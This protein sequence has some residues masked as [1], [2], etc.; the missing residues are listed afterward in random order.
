MTGR[1]QGFE[2][3]MTKIAISAGLALSALQGRVAQGARVA[4]GI[5]SSMGHAAASGARATPAMGALVRNAGQDVRATMS[6][7]KALSNPVTQGMQNRVAD[8]IR[9]EAG[10]AV[11]R[12]K[13]PLSSAYEGYMNTQGAHT[14][15]PQH[16]GHVL[17]VDPAGIKL[18]EGPTALMPRGNAS[19][20]KDVL[21]NAA[22]EID[23]TGRTHLGG[24]TQVGQ[25]GGRNLSVPSAPVVPLDQPGIGAMPTAG[26]ADR[27]NPFAGRARRAAGVPLP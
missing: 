22:T 17:G 11:T 21:G 9:H 24:R 18:R 19:L 8:A 6:M 7:N 2:S 4:P 16:M 10:G 12:T 23:A 15:T 3:E 27:T 1:R 26:H 13:S 20:G 14:Y 5:L 25:I